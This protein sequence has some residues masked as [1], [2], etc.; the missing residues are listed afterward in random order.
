MN[1]SSSTRRCWG[2][3]YEIDTGKSRPLRT[4]RGGRS[5]A[6]AAG[7]AGGVLVG[8]DPIGGIHDQRF[9]VGSGRHN[10]GYGGHDR[11]AGCEV[12]HG[13]GRCSDGHLCPLGRAGHHSSAFGRGGTRDRRSYDRRSRVGVRRSRG[14]NG[15]GVAVGNGVG[16]SR[17]G[18]GV[19]VGVG[20]DNGR[21]LGGNDG[22]TSDVIHR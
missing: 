7:R 12:R 19:G 6:G 14:G 20:V 22:C 10:R 9:G 21:S 1:V 18:N 8:R 15:V 13:R 4:A 3:E 11:P 16:R 2:D 5:R 17:G